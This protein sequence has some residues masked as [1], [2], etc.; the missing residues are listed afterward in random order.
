VSLGD[1]V[2]GFGVHIGEMRELVR[3]ADYEEK[4]KSKEL[5]LLDTHTLK[6]DGCESLGD[7]IHISPTQRSQRCSAYFQEINKPKETTK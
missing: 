3:K 2:S 6:L 7:S 5:G 4:F 1:I